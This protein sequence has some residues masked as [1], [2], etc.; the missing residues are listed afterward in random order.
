MRLVLDSFAA[1]EDFSCS[2]GHFAH[3]TAAKR[4][5]ASIHRS[6]CTNSNDELGFYYSDFLAWRFIDVEGGGTT[7]FHRD[8]FYG[9]A[10]AVGTKVT[11][12]HFPGAPQ[13]RAFPILPMK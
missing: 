8:T 1:Q 3:C 7:F 4:W 2:P 5:S 6:L 10:V 13:T 12:A 11:F 9:N